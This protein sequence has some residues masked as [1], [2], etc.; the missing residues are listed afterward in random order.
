M[1]TREPNPELDRLAHAVIGA[2][3][4]VHRVL[5]SGFLESV[6]EQAMAVELGIRGIPFER[7]KLIG[8]NYKNTQVDE[9]KI[10]MLVGGA[11][12]VELKATDKLTPLHSAQVIS[13]L[14]AT[15]QPLGLLINFKV[16]QLREG[17]KRIVLS[18]PPL[19]WRTSLLSWPSWRPWRSW[20]LSCSS[21][22]PWRLSARLFCIQTER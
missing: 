3:I 22:C 6:Y 9:G 11:L 13:Y 16:R 4:E 15:G 19:P 1:N 21:L 20:R 8:V 10:D 18:C 5:G 14:K 7:Q 2:A 12:V 17:V